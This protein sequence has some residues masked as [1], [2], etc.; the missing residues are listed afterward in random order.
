MFQ[1]DFAFNPARNIQNILFWWDPSTAAKIIGGP[2]NADGYSRLVRRAGFVDGVPNAGTKFSLAPAINTTAGGLTYA[3]PGLRSGVVAMY[4]GTSLAALGLTAATIVIAA[5]KSGN[6]DSKA[7]YNRFGGAGD[8]SYHGFSG[9]NNCYDDFGSTVRQTFSHTVNFT[10][11]HIICTRARTGQ[12]DFWADGVN[13]FSTTTNTFSFA[14]AT[15]I[16]GAQIPKFNTD[17]GYYEV[18]VI[19]RYITDTEMWSLYRYM[20]AKW[21]IPLAAGPTKMRL[22]LRAGRRIFTAAPAFTW[23]GNMTPGQHQPLI[24]RPEMVPYG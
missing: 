18:L 23:S 3:G 7:Y 8:D 13:Q 19:G 14:G 2:D 15:A 11:N 10:G 5:S 24:T 17:S 4:L 22:G 16:S 9:D 1:R 20:S 12:W 21:K 6:N